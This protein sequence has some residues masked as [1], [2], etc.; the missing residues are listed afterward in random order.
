MF[1]VKRIW[2]ARTA[3]REARPA[4]PEPGDELVDIAQRCS[5]AIGVDTFG[6]DVV[7]SDG[8][9]YVVDLSSWP[10]FKGVPAVEGRLAAVIELAAR[11]ALSGE[12]VTAGALP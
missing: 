10:G 12:P 6:F 9:P 2:P 1:G 4:V 5:A 8:V 7:F 11:R 3:R